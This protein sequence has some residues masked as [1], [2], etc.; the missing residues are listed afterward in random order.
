M[1]PRAC[2]LPAHSL[3]SSLKESELVELAHNESVT[4]TAPH[5][6]HFGGFGSHILPA[7]FDMIYSTPGMQLISQN[8]VKEL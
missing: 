6:A 2:W 8:F 1:A 3:A 4:S 5:R 7:S